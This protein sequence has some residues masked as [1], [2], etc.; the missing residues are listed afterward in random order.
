MYEFT[1]SILGISS[2]IGWNAVLSSMYYFA[3][4]FDN[5]VFNLYSVPF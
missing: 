4:K 3:K 2:I 1:F 5:S